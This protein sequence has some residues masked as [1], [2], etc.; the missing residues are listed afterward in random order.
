MANYA[1]DTDLQDYE[2][3]ILTESGIDSFEK[4][5]T[6]ASTEV[7]NKIKTAWWP[8]ASSLPISYFDEANLNVLAIKQYTIY[9]AFSKY[10]FIKLATFL[11]DDT[12][13]KKADFYK[14]LAAEEWDII[15]GLPLY[16][17]DKDTLF[18]DSER[19]SPIVREVGRG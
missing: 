5:L 6:L 12:Y 14:E 18:E 8:Q 4:Q 19:R 9:V 17:F 2:E 7:L 13:L 15:K 3:N 16:D 10:I 11:E 1:E